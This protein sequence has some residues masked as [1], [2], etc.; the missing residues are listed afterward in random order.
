M[1]ELV[2]PIDQFLKK[3][4]SNRSRMSELSGI[5][6]STLLNAV[7]RDTSVL[8]LR[9]NLLWALQVYFEPKKT[10]NDVLEELLAY[11]YQNEIGDDEM[12]S[13]N[14]EGRTRTRLK[15]DG[16]KL[17]DAYAINTAGVIKLKT[18]FRKLMQVRKFEKKD[19][20]ISLIIQYH[21][22]VGM[23]VPVQFAR[24]DDRR[25]FEEYTAVFMMGLTGG[26]EKLEEINSEYKAYVNNAK[27]DGS[28]LVDLGDYDL[29]QLNEN[30][31]V[32]VLHENIKGWKTKKSKKTQTSYLSEKELATIRDLI[33]QYHDASDS[34]EAFSIQQ[35]IEDIL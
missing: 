10:L 26:N 8:N 1:S 25:T 20:F 2:H 19:E 31:I 33:E 22:A 14:Q 34:D 15:L 30:E 35:S 29:Y 27:K 18:M 3:R 21:A 23:E 4:D 28:F 16:T 24:M 7:K 11:E 12:G 9:V 17:R 5:P 13:S 32:K 6:T